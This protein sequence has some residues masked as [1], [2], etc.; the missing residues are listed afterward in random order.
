MK[1]ITLLGVAV[2][3]AAV[4]AIPTLS[5]ADGTPVQIGGPVVGGYYSDLKP[6][7]E[8]SGEALPSTPVIGG[9]Y[10]DLKPFTE[11]SGQTLPYTAVIGGYYGDLKPFTQY[12]GESHP[13]TAIA[14]QGSV[15]SP[16]DH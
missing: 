3:L 12:S 7:A 15:K 8:Y 16:T 6:F 5:R 14:G 10:S 11:Y 9:Y 13:D 2:L 4:I 1:K